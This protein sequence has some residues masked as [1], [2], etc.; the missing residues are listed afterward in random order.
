MRQPLLDQR[1]HQVVGLRVATLL[2]L[3]PAPERKVVRG[4]LAQLSLLIVELGEWVLVFEDLDRI[5]GIRDLLDQLLLAQVELT[6]ARGDDRVARGRGGLGLALQVE[7]SAPLD[8]SLVGRLGA[9]EDLGEAR[10]RDSKEGGR[11]S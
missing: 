2:D 4:R 6:L 10:L 5:A 3:R 8:E 9:D 11:R 1:L 7:V